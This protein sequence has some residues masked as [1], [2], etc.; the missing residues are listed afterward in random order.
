[1]KNLV[2]TLIVLLLTVSSVYSQQGNESPTDNV[3]NPNGALDGKC[4]SEWEWACG[5]Y[6]ARFYEGTISSVPSYCQILVDTLPEQYRRPGALAYNPPFLPDEGTAQDNACNPGGV[7]AGKCTTDWEWTCGYYLARYDSG[8]AL[9]VPSSCQI[10]LDVRPQI[11]QSTP[12]QTVGASQVCIIS[13]QSTPVKKICMLG[14][15]LTEDNEPADGTAEATYFLTSEMFA[16][17]AGNCPAGTTY[18]NDIISFVSDII[19]FVESQGIPAAGDKCQ[20]P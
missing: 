18:A 17:Y 20:Y 3:C 9:G 11:P 5:W 10:L 16:G 13:L 8:Q 12:P 4:D 7:M 1:M 15:I 2:I 6:L 14:N 19:L